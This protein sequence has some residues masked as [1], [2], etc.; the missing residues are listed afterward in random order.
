MI[1]SAFA[2]CDFRIVKELTYYALQVIDNDVI[3][4]KDHVSFVTFH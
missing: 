3:K 4:T 1:A 2:K